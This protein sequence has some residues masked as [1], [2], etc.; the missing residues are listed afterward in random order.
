MRY[1]PSTYGRHLPKVGYMHL[2]RVGAAGAVADLMSYTGGVSPAS[3]G[4]YQ[5]AAQ[6]DREA[7]LRSSVIETPPDRQALWLPAYLDNAVLGSNT[8][9]VIPA[10]DFQAE[11]FTVSANAGNFEIT[12]LRIG[13]RP[14]FAAAGPIPAAQFA[15]NSLA[16]RACAGLVKAGTPIQLIVNCLVPSAFR[17]TFSG[18]A[19]V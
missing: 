7:V 11:E 8:I 12:D 6:L 5:A 1:I 19:L 17:G 14:L 16:S 2:P 9:T 13:M 18:S 3:L 4:A 15:P 10:C